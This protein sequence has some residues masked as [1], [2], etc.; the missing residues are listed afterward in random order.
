[1][2]DKLYGIHGDALEL[3][4]R[5]ME[6]LSTN[7]ANAD[8]PAFKAKDIDFRKVLSWEVGKGA[9][10]MTNER[11]LA[12]P[13]ALDGGEVFTIPYNTAVDG[14][15]VEIGLEQAKF[16]KAAVEYQATLDFLQSRVT[17]YKRALKGE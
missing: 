1:M 3:K 4:S 12:S 6:I 2:L 14:N 10:M 9:M 16:G 15:T 5:R 13:F 11:H 7:I 17:A 8:T